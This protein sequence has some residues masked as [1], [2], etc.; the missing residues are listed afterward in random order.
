MDIYSKTYEHAYRGVRMKFAYRQLIYNFPLS[1]LCVCVFFS[2]LH[3]R[4]NV[5]G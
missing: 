4:Y 2:F 1:L 3:G 5:V